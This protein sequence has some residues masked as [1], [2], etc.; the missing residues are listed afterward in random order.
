MVA[1]GGRGGTGGRGGGNPGAAGGFG[2]R[3]TADI[4]VTP[5]QVLFVRVGGPGANGKSGGPRGNVAGGF[6]G[7]GDSG[8]ASDNSGGARLT[9][10]PWP[11]G[12]RAPCCRG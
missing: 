3:A 4:P 2:A 11:P 12:T 5:G 8:D 9:F 6:N 10:A 1:V 7:G